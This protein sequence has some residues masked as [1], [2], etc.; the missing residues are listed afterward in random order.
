MQG[1]N[2]QLRLNW[3]GFTLDAAF[4]APGRGAIQARGPPS[5][6]AIRALSSVRSADLTT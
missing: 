3:P 4:D 2:V 5:S 6:D 1:I